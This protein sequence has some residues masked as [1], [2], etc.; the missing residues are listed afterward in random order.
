VLALARRVGLGDD[1]LHPAPLPAALAIGGELRPL[2]AGTLM[3]VPADPAAVASVADVTG[4]D[5]DEGRPLL[6]PGEDVAVGALVRARLGDDVVDRLV[7]PLLGGV[8]AG[9]AD[10]LSLAATVPGLHR[11]AGR[12]STLAAAV[13]EALA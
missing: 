8:Y 3:G 6:A 7:D 2:P 1:L 10:E 5:R 12:Q 9:R 4:K 13:R 11:A